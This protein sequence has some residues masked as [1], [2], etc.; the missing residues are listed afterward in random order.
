MLIGMGGA[1]TLVSNMLRLPKWSREREGQMEYIAGR[2][3]SLLAE[4][5]ELRVDD[6]ETYTAPWTVAFN[7]KRDDDYQQYEYACHEGN[8]AVPNSLSGARAQERP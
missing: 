3:G 7:F 6:P 2:V 5:Y 4:P 1:G 8:Y